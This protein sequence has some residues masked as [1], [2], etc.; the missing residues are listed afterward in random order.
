MLYLY[1]FEHI[2]TCFSDVM[3]MGWGVG[4][5]VCVGF[6]YDFYQRFYDLFVGIYSIVIYLYYIILYYRDLSGT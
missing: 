6:G 1:F 5:N 4:Q 3:V 2:S